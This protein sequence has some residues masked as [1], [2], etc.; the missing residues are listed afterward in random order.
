MKKLIMMIAVSL[1]VVGCGADNTSQTNDQTNQTDFIT[2]MKDREGTEF[3][4]PEQMNKIISTSTA[5]TEILVG[6]G[7]SDSLAVI[8]IYAAEN[9]DAPKDAVA[10]DF[11]TPNIEALLSMECDIVIASD[12]N[13][14]GGIDPYIQL[15]EAGIPVVYI[16]TSTSIS[17]IYKD[18]EFLGQ[19]TN[20]T[21]EAEA[22]I[23]DMQERIQTVID[24]VA[25]EE[26]KTVYFEISPA[27][28]MYATGQNT[29][30]NEAITLAG[31]INIIEEDG[32]ISPSE[33]SILSANPEII[34]TNVERIETSVEDIK[35]RDGWDTIEAV[36]QDEVYLV[37]ANT[38]ARAS[39]HVVIAVEEIAKAIHGDVFE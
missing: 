30:V 5:N 14:V 28:S 17:E 33:E 6:L 25:E 22:M 11:Y 19:L 38:S 36:I 10:M 23:E 20:T 39:Q 27:P 29:F 34:I 16:P 8:D 4:V 2:T 7:L 21:K 3:T 9:D 35:N 1:M 13:R 32:F 15:E 12:I 26:P 24:V 31:G 37:G 18:I